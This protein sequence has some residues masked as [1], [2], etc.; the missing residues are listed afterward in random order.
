MAL[1]A[2]D[3]RLAAYMVE[4]QILP[5]DQLLPTLREADARGEPLGPFLVRSGLLDGRGLERLWA[6]VD[7]LRPESPSSELGKTLITETLRRSSD[8]APSSTP[9]PTPNPSP[10]REP[11]T[12]PLMGARTRAGGASSASVTPRSGAPAIELDLARA[13]A[14][15]GPRYQLFGELARGGMG[16]IL[17][18]RDTRIGREVAVKV[19]IDGLQAS[20]ADRRRFFTEVQATGQLE[21]PSIIPIHDVGDLPT[22]EPFYVMKLLSGR[23]LAEILSG[24]KRAIPQVVEEFTRTRLLTVFQQICYAVAF[25]HARGVIHRDIKPPNIMI[26][27]YGEATLLDWGLAKLSR[28]AAQRDS[29]AP[30]VEVDRGFDGFE[31][32]EGTITGTPQYMAP[33]AVEGRNEVIGEPSDVYGLGAVLYEILT[34][35]PA[36]TDEGF[37]RTLVRVRA[38]DFVR[39]RLRAPERNVSPELEELCLWAMHPQH[40]QRPS[41]KQLADDIGSILEGTRER[42]RRQA[43]ARAR[44][45]EGRAAL[46]RWRQLK[47]EL[48]AVDGLARRLSK[49]VPQ[50]GPVEEKASIWE[51]EDRASQL[52]IEAIGA[53]EETEAAL[54]RALGEIPDDREARGLLAALYYERFAEAERAR[55]GEGERYYKSLVARY[56]D[57]A[58]AR[59]LSGRGRLTVRA[60]EDG[61][62]VQI[63]RL[64][65]KNRVLTPFE[66]RSLGSAPIRGL[67][68]PIGSYLLTLRPRVGREVSRPVVIGRLEDVEVE[69]RIRGDAEIGADFVFVPG[70]ACVL[71]GDPI[72]HGSLERRVV[73][74]PDFAIGR[75][76]ITCAEYLIF[77]NDLARR[78]MQAALRHV[79]RVTEDEGHY[80]PPHETQ[81]RY[82]LPAP[83]EGKGRWAPQNPVFGVSFADALAY[84]AW[85]SKLTGTRLRLPSEDEWEKAARG[86]DGRFFPW[87]DHFDPTFC[88]MKDSRSQGLEPEPVG[89]FPTDRSSYGAH[90]FAGGVRELCVS[91]GEDGEDVPVMR[92]GCWH[93]TGLFCRLAFRHVTKPDFVNTGLGFRM[94]REL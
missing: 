86:V 19:L 93:D 38:G 31:T 5:L 51:L 66:P 45:Q 40:E 20:E 64:L 36:F 35:E 65:P 30:L 12:D 91:H 75:F 15:D 85:R 72:A 56:D 41:A 1:S 21:H 37:M 71:G 58:W 76:P 59:V 34:L 47:E 78:D 9:I 55:D 7:R 44:I 79:P 52:K 4:I 62:E 8:P 89:T 27:R 13:R 81:R 49:Q 48:G 11:T 10:D 33:E 14:S 28:G 18:S 16:R 53:F 74:V 29:D 87:G 83:V 2:E 90:D 39:P 69:V 46:E 26:G 17:R 67:D 94:V 77:I 57:G 60:S 24:L 68:L 50:W 63:A 32:A 82:V 23:T 92:G 80:W 42:E 25:A 22:G 73:D 70:G 88:K 3:R 43:E 6:D 61:V 84:C 54:L